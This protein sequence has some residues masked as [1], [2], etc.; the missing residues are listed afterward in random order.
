MAEPAAPVVDADIHA[1]VPAIG[2]LASYLDPQWAD[3]VGW[4][5]FDTPRAVSFNYPRWN[6]M[7]SAESTLEGL[8]SALGDATERAMLTCYYGVETVTN[9]YCAEAL[10]NA[11]NTWL[12]EEWLDKDSRLLGTI[13]IA[14]DRSPQALATIE[15]FAVDRRFR[16][17]LLPIR[18]TRPYGDQSFW[19]IYEAAVAHDLV[20]V[21]AMGG[22]PLIRWT[23]SF[24]EDLALA[25]NA[26]KVH[27]TSLVASG[28][29]ARWPDLRFTVAE[30]GWSW[31]PGLMWRLD[32][33]WKEYRTE[34]PW[35]DGPPSSYVRRFFRFTTTPSDAPEDRGRLRE[36]IE[37]IGGDEIEGHR[38]LLYSSDF[39]HDHGAYG[40][41]LLDVFDAQ[42]SRRVL[43]ENALEWYGS[44]IAQ[45]VPG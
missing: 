22:S 40:A 34:I 27:I 7:F 39:P 12:A 42:A 8:R 41:D 32:Q 23:P 2:E 19:P 17:I 36:I 1:G 13:T 45:P 9:P 30:G 33:E 38:L 20:P 25:S 14:P 16:Q 4:T 10:A 3:F 31:L 24:Y 29:F 21:L 18:A 6:P 28:V 5:N 44:G 26:F 37:Q 15:K 35:L 43:Y 11:V